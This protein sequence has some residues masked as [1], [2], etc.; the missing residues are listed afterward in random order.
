MR[1]AER[2][3]RP[4]DVDGEVQAAPDGELAD[5]EVAA[6]LARRDRPQALAPLGALRHGAARVGRQRRRAQRGLACRRAGQQLVR[7][8]DR[9][10]PEERP[11]G[12]RD[13][14][15][16]FRAR[17]AVGDVPAHEQR[18]GEAVG[19]QPEA[20]DDRR[21]PDRVAVQREQLDD[22]H[23][24]RSGPADRHGTGQRVVGAEVD[25][26]QRL[27]RGRAAQLA[28]HP[29]AAVRLELVAG[30]DRRDGGDARVQP[31][32]GRAG[33][34]GQD[35]G[36]AIEDEA[37]PHPTSL[38]MSAAARRAR[39]RSSGAHSRVPPSTWTETMPTSRSPS[40]TAVTICAESP[41]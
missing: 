1:V 38:P 16:L 28:V 10:G 18:L 7:R 5:V 9:H 8:R 20:R 23:V 26:A 3:Q 32:V 14:G 27:R 12:D 40:R 35:R 25:V 41:P 2:Q 34:V 30:I 24:A 21:R 31:V 17:D 19:Q 36:V 13:A 33:I 37:V 29:V 6:V 22:E 4:V 39:P 15:Q 11:P